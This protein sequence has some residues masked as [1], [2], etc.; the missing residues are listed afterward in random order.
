MATTLLAVETAL[1][2]HRLKLDEWLDTVYHQSHADREYSGELDC[3]YDSWGSIESTVGIVFESELTQQ[4]SPDALDSVLFFAS[5]NEEIGCIIAWMGRIGP[6]SNAG[7][8]S[9]P[10]FTFL[11]ETSLSRSEDYVDY[12]LVNCFHKIL[13]LTT[14]QFDIVLRFFRRD[15]A[16]T[17]RCA[18]DV[19]ATKGF[20]GIPDLAR[21]LWGH[22]DC[23][24]TKLSALTALKHSSSDDSLF[25]DLLVGF[26]TRFPVDDCEYRV[27]NIAF[28]ES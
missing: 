6:F 21:D 26:K 24:Y 16:Y 9:L 1:A 20:T 8:L 23:E 15:Y 5:R 28:L 22:D 13:D 2:E 11:C 3:S 27:K 4:L 18:I 7:R 10:D 14:T 17:K 19:L 12:E 25:R